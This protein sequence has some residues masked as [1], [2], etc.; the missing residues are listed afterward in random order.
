MKTLRRKVIALLSS[1][2]RQVASSL[3]AVVFGFGVAVVPASAQGIEPDADKILRTMTSYLA[4]LKSFTADYDADSEVLDLAGQKL[5][6]SASG[7]IAVER[8]GNLHVTREGA[9]ADAEIKFAGKAVSILGKKINAYVQIDSPGPT[10]DEAVDEVRAATGLDAPGADLI[11]ADPYAVL[12]EDATQGFHVGTGFVG[13]T[14]C[15]H[16]AFRNP[17][18]DWQIWIQKG[19]QPLPLKYV[20]TTK[21]VTGAPQ[22]TLRLSNWN[23][24]PQFDA[25]EFTFI[26][27][28]DATKLEGLQADAIGEVALEE[29]Q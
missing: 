11:I 19:E 28:P 25:S 12:V 2:C 21:W 22:F 4:G 7:T 3:A 17:R 14:E 27:P 8:P 23:V 29:R 26:A 5:Q 15:E 1:G 9:F 13:R 24:A 10:I 18:V 20:I 6:Y 16:L